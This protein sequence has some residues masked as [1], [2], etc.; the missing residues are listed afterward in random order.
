MYNNGGHTI[1]YLTNE[2]PAKWE[3]LYNSIVLYPNDQC[4]DKISVY[5]VNLVIKQQIASG[6]HT[7]AP[8]NVEVGVMVKLNTPMINI[9][10]K[11][12]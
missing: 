3:I 1:L 11:S 4:C 7:I 2:S 9:V 12:M 10:M 5:N 8:L 6:K